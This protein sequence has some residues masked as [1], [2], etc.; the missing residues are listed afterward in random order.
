M[1]KVEG[2]DQKSLFEGWEELHPFLFNACSLPSFQQVSG[3]GRIFFPYLARKEVSSC[4]LRRVRSS[5]VSREVE[6]ACLF[7]EVEFSSF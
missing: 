7:I 3:I 6:G 2:E 1:L 4:R 5:L